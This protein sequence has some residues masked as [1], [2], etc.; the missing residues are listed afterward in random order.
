M[1]VLKSF[2]REKDRQ[3]ELKTE[4]E[5]ERTILHFKRIKSLRGRR[6]SR[7]RR[8]SDRAALIVDK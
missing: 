7:R 3:T 2:L 1:K 6:K 8:Q 4:R 5:R